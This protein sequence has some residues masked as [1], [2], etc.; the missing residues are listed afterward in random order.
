MRTIAVVLIML[1]VGLLFHGT[2]EAQNT[3]GKYTIYSQPIGLD[4]TLA[5]GGTTYSKILS[6]NRQYTQANTNAG[7]PI[8]FNANQ[9]ARIL[10]LG[11][12]TNDSVH[13]YIYLQ[14]GNITGG[15][16]GK[17]YGEV[18]VDSLTLT[19]AAVNMDL[20]TYKVFKE[21]RIKMVGLAAGNGVLA[22]WSANA[23][24]IGSPVQ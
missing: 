21:A 5:N 8:Y 20:S 15:T 18:L 6:L 19:K 2:A 7:Q 12:Q 22:K 13:S 11:R 23:A 9:Y 14:Y 4:T 16:K 17:D 3:I 10:V 24:I 1:A